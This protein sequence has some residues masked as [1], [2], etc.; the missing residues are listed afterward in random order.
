MKKITYMLAIMLMLA[1]ILS[2]S[3]KEHGDNN[4]TQAM[5]FGR[6]QIGL[7]EVIGSVE[8]VSGGRVVK[9]E[10]EQQGKLHPAKKGLPMFEVESVK[11]GTMA[12]YYVDPVTGKVIDQKK[13]WWQV[14][15]F[16][17]P[18][19]S[20]GFAKVKVPMVQAVSVAEQA[21]GGKAMSAKLKERHGVF[22]YMIRTIA[23]SNIKIVLID[24]DNG[25][26]YMEPE[27]NSTKCSH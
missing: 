16:D 19:K 7:N 8:K 14:F 11:D 9:I 2:V 18:W 24:P 21:S 22:F 5:A 4:L 25:K 26:V 17:S 1:P 15:D 20:E 23:D 3:G 12:K 10:I 27:G 6:T 13:V